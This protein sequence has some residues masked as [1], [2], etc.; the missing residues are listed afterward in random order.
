LRNC[1]PWLEAELDLL[2]DL[3]VVVALGRIA[4]DL[5]LSLLKGRGLIARRGA[6]LFGHHRVHHLGAGLP[7]LV[8]SYHP[9]QQNTSTG[10]LT[11]EMLTRVFLTARELLP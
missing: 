6:F 4:F 3:R 5:Y 11:M 7:V 9:S 10:K 8:S 1:R 2:P